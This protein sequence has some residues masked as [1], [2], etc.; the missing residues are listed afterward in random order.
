MKLFLFGLMKTFSADYLAKAITPSILHNLEKFTC[1]NRKKNSDHHTWE[2][3]KY[4]I[5]L[6]YKDK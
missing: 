1:N 2:K 5:I 6:F 3:D 4:L